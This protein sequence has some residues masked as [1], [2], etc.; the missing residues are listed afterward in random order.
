MSLARKLEPYHHENVCLADLEARPG[1]CLCFGTGGRDPTARAGLQREDGKIPRLVAQV[2][3]WQRSYAENVHRLNILSAR[4]QELEGEEE[5]YES[6]QDEDESKQ[7][8]YNDE[9]SIAV[10]L[11]YL[12]IH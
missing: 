4:E 9:Q 7:E 1:A 5:D 2:E 8:E 10:K 11:G 6:A 3:E 12:R